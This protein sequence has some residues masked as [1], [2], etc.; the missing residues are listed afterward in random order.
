MEETKSVKKSNKLIEAKGKMTA[1]EQKFFLALVSQIDFNDRDFKEYEIPTKIF[2]ELIGN[3]YGTKIYTD[4]HTSA[5]KLMNKI[6]TI[7]TDETIITTALLSS[8]ETPK[9][10]GV[11]KVTFHP[12][13]KPYLIDVQNKFTQYQLKNVLRLVSP[14]SIRI[15]ELLKQYEKIKKRMF[16]IKEFKEFLG[17]ENGYDRFDNLE[18]RILKTAKTEINEK[19]DIFINYKKIKEGR[20]ITKL[21]FTIQPK[22]TGKDEEKELIDV[23]YSNEQIQELKTKCGLPDE[24]FNNTQMIELYE[25]ACEKTVKYDLDPHT[26]IELNY[27]YSIGKAKHMYSYLKKA[28]EEDYANAIMS[29][30]FFMPNTATI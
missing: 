14:H 28:L 2:I 27:K 10:K 20:K 19:T 6:L 1:L 22:Q 17:I 21:E 5:R 3:K 7:E 13:L 25:I 8:V 24:T 11:V 9:G 18:R 16:K 15:Y 23:L 4:I 12:S 30:K 29:M 26:Y